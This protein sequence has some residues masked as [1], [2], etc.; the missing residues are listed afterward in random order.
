MLSGEL[1]PPTDMH[2]APSMQRVPSMSVLA[3][4]PE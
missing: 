3:P 4:A 2:R 1:A